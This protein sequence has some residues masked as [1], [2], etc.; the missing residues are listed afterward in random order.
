MNSG[1]IIRKAKRKDI[2]SIYDIIKFYSDDG[3]ILKRTRTDILGFLS[4]FYVA[5]IDRTIAGTISFFDYGS[6]LKEI[7]SLGVKKEFLRHGIGSLLLKR[8]IQ[9]LCEENTP[10]IFVLTLNVNFFEK[11][12]FS[13][14]SMDS[15]PEKIWKDCRTCKKIESCDET[16]LEYNP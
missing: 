8:A 5:E 14:I 6:H 13:V 15:L 12:G 1:A 2:D 11:N 7:R 10:R 3:I 9:Y 16:A 4:D